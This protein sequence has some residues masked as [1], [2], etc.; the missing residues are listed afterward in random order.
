F[1]DVLV[2]DGDGCFGGGTCRSVRGAWAAG[3]TRAA[4]TAVPVPLGAENANKVAARPAAPTA[5]PA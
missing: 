2:G 1:G 4:V 5:T 3:A